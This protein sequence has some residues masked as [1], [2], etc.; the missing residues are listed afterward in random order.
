LHPDGAGIGRLR[1]ALAAIMIAAWKESDDSRHQQAR[2]TATYV[3]L[4]LAK[5]SYILK[6]F[7]REI[8]LPAAA[9][10][11]RFVSQ[12]PRNFSRQLS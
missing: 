5:T 1:P 2:Q 8:C 10:A 11:C 7:S 6:V 9:Y 4:P 12:R 3:T